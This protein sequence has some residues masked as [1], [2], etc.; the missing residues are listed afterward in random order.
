MD[1]GVRR[2]MIVAQG[3]LVVVCMLFAVTAIIALSFTNRTN[4][5][6]RQTGDDIASVDALRLRLTRLA[7]A[8]LLADDGL[9]RFGEVEGGVD[10]ARQQLRARARGSYFAIDA[11]ALDRDADDLKAAIDHAASALVGDPRA[12]F[13]A[14][15]VALR[16]VRD[17]FDAD[18]TSLIHKLVAHR[19]E[20]FERSTRVATRARWALVF[21]AAVAILLSLAFAAAVMRALARQRERTRDA[22]DHATRTAASRKELL[23]ASKDLRSP[24]EFILRASAELRSAP[25]ERLADEVHAAAERLRGLVDDLLDVSGVEAGT[26]DLRC[27]R[28][29][30]RTLIDVAIKSV[31]LLAA[32]RAIRVVVV[33][34]AP[35]LVYV[36]RRR[37]DQVLATL[38]GTAIRSAR[39][40]G[41]VTVTARATQQGARFAISET[42]APM[43]PAQLMS[44]FDR[45]SG[46]VFDQSTM[47]V[48][49][50]K[51]LVEAH[52]GR[53]GIE[54][55]A[56]WFSL[57]IEPRLLRDPSTR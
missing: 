54:G 27:E 19:D 30:A 48:H 16:P 23:A 22:A 56:L 29:D 51:R 52:G 28:C 8:V 53:V 38:I 43:L 12:S 21:T 1:P 9:V 37:M 33:V 2:R 4:G 36:D 45:P 26:V 11:D 42:G 47:E 34:P 39:P 15:R 25:N 46:H 20:S 41:E 32:E 35:I 3:G 10:R 40:G 44:L 5:T 14:Y 31:Q 57:P 6:L 7:A 50:S 18:A 17:A 13:V 24:I 49:V 55:T